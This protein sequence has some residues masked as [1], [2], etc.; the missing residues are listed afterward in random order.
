VGLEHDAA[1]AAE[2]RHSLPSEVGD[3]L[4]AGMVLLAASSALAL[5]PSP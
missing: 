4:L 2:D 3:Q 1:V 5:R